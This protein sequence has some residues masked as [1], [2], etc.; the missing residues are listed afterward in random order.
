MLAPPSLY[1]ELLHILEHVASPT[2]PRSSLERLA[3]LSTGILGASSCVLKQVA[4]ELHSLALGPAQAESIERRLRRTLND[5]HL[6]HETIYAPL[7]QRLV[8]WEHL[9]G[10]GHPLVL[11]IDESSKADEIHLFRAS[12]TFQGSAVPLAWAIWQQNAPLAQGAY[13]QYVDAVLETVATMVPAE[14]EVVAVADRAFD[15]PPFVD[16]V[17]ALGWHWVVRAKAKGTLRFRDHQ[18]REHALKDLIARSVRHPGQRWKARGWIFKESGWREA[19]VVALWAAGEDEPLV[20]L[21][22]LPPRWSVLALFGRRFWVEPGFRNDKK[23]GWK[24]ESS[25]VQGVEHH[26]QLLM[27][28]AVATLVALCLGIQEGKVRLARLETRPITVG[29]TAGLPRKA[30]ESLFT[31]G[32]ARAKRWLYGNLPQVGRWLIVE[33]GPASWSQTWHAHQSYRYIFHRPLP[34]GAPTGFT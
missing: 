25:Q 3:A 5:P 13:W 4:S 23:R 6:R 24:W 30:K 34:R 22:D 12:F 31:L 29:G 19:S 14:T 16:R 18:G 21:T 1:Q 15:I 20:V 32:V 7:L 26:Q 28:M 10:P 8:A 33:L 2:V 17:A 11:A 27:G 9:S